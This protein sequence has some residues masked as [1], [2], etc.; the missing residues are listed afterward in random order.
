MTQLYIYFLSSSAPFFRLLLHHIL[1]LITLGLILHSAQ[2]L[3]GY[4]YLYI[5]GY[6]LETDFFSFSLSLYCCGS[7]WL[8]LA[9]LAG[10][11]RRAGS[12]QLFKVK[13]TEYG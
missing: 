5:S 4:M 6:H 3:Y 1:I 10:Q 8:H 2:T 7:V 11:N 12:F 9:E 13:Q